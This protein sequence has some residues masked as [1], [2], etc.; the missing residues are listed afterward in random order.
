MEKVDKDEQKVNAGRIA[1]GSRVSIS[2][3][4][5]VSKESEMVI[6]DDALLPTLLN[7]FKSKLNV[8]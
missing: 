4:K 6:H 2:K 1:V 8:S 5:E 3:N 7:K